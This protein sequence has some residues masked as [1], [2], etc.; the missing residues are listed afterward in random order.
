V[1]WVAFLACWKAK[2]IKP[3]SFYRW[4]S[5][6]LGL[7]VLVF[8]GWACWKSYHIS[9]RM[10]LPL[11]GGKSVGRALA[12]FRHDGQTVLV[13]A[14]RN[15]SQLFSFR[16]TPRR[17]GSRGVMGFRESAEQAGFSWILILDSL[18]LV[19]FVGLWSAWLFCHW[20][21]DQRKLTPC[22]RALSGCE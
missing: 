13:K 7:C 20:K 15:A 12:G 2:D 9:V 6:W 10:N 8:L 5:F 18:V 22:G 19:S 14:H 11:G 21:R 4:K 16:A 1:G 3:S 17:G